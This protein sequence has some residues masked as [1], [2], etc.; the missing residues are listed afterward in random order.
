MIH[1]IKLRRGGILYRLIYFQDVLIENDSI[2]ML[3][4]FVP[5]TRQILV[6]DILKIHT[7]SIF[8]LVSQ[9]CIDS[10]IAP[11]Q[12]IFSIEPPPCVVRVEVFVSYGVVLVMCTGFSITPEYSFPVPIPKKLEA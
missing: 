1:N 11:E 7:N 9:L 3:L 4:Q 8:K 12:N 10:Q 2:D 5:E 6:L